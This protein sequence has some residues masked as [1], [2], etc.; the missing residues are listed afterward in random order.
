M[1]ADVIQRVNHLG[2]SQNMPVGL[3]FAGRYK[4]EL[5]ESDDSDVETVDTQHT[6]KSS[7]TSLDADDDSD[8]GHLPPAHSQGIND[9]LGGHRPDSEVTQAG[10]ITGV[11]PE[12]SS[13]DHDQQ[14][15]ADASSDEP[16]SNHSS[17]GRIDQEDSEETQSGE[18]SSDHDSTQSVDLNEFPALLDEEGNQSASESES[19]NKSMGQ[20]SVDTGQVEECPAAPAGV[21]GQA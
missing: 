19:S 6:S 13:D 14:S 3:E 10:Q 11:V 1:P 9:R 17:E 5:A 8:D 7:S 20:S 21:P 18:L 15:T 12:Y 2:E 4:D 16:T